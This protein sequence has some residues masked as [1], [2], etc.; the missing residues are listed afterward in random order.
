[1]NLLSLSSSTR[2]RECASC[3]RRIPPGPSIE[4]Y[5]FKFTY[6]LC[7]SCF[8]Y[9]YSAFEYAVKKA[10]AP[11]AVN[12]FYR[13]I[14]AINYVDKD[15]SINGVN[16]NQD[17]DF[18]RKIIDFYPV[19]P[20]RFPAVIYKFHSKLSSLTWDA[21]FKNLILKHKNPMIRSLIIFSK[22]L[23]SKQQ[24]IYFKSCVSC[25]KFLWWAILERKLSLEILYSLSPL[26]IFTFFS[27]I[28]NSDQIA[29]FSSPVNIHDLKSL[30]LPLFKKYEGL[31]ILDVLDKIEE[32]IQE[33]K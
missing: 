10:K 11:I 20:L 6:Y 1:M 24:K 16:P 29:L 7:F 23:T 15:K 8:S 14:L 12:N 2:Y 22:D 33:K 30:F 3:H 18:F 5:A 27:N 13:E 19:D 31:N 21:D 32:L 17:L 28:S 25:N 26:Q 9:H 4:V